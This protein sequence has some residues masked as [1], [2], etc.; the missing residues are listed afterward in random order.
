MRKPHLYKP[1]KNNTLRALAVCTGVFLCL[2]AGF[3]GALSYLKSKG[4]ARQTEQLETALRRACVTC[5]AV[6]GRY[7]RDLAYITERY[8]VVI[9][10]RSYIVRYDAFAEN[11]LPQIV[12]LPREA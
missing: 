5:Y 3:A 8:G 12:V 2:V 10:E 4:A 11:L 1:G 7:P 6:E 9:D